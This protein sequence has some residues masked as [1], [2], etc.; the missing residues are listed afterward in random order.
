MIS[1]LLATYNGADT[2]G[3]T[4]DAMTGVR[5]PR[6]G[7]ELIVVDNGSTDGT[8]EIVRRF[9]AD[10]PLAYLFEPCPGKSAALNRGLDRSAGGLVVMTDDDVLP[11]PGWLEAYEAAA[12]AHPAV[13]VFSGPIEPHWD[14]PPPD[15]VLSCVPPDAAFGISDPDQP[16]GEVAAERVW[17]ANMAVRRDVVRAG[18]RFDAALGPRGRRY[19]YGE[20]TDFQARLARAGHRARHVRAA[21]VAHI[22]AAAQVGRWWLLRRAVALG[23]Y[24]YYD[25]LQE[26]PRRHV[27][28][29]PTFV[30]RG[31]AAASLRAAGAGLRG[32]RA[33]AFGAQWELARL[34]D[35]ALEGRA[36]WRSGRPT[37]RMPHPNIP[38]PALDCRPAARPR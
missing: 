36:L 24:A 19:R 22:I 21:A 37:R 11:V 26:R 28:G 33:A 30:M 31:I 3:R 1:V 16:D 38:E 32:D 23:R 6:G 7:W 25:R 15:F 13:A 12:D 5:P 2:I 35:H 14:A 8:R 34:L 17:G 10:L 20:D 9:A 18:Y 4:L 29:W 27:R